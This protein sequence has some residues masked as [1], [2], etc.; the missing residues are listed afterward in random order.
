MEKLENLPAW[1]M[2]KNQEQK[3]AIQEAQRKEMDSSCC[4]ADGHK[5]PQKTLSWI[6]SSKNTRRVVLRSDTERQ[7]CLLR[8]GLRSKVR[9]RH[10]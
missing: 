4:N 5:P 10:K 2:S 9:Q 1:Q 3:E 7:F 8:C 6:R